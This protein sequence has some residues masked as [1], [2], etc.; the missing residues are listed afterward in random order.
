[1][2]KSPVAQYAGIKSPVLAGFR[3]V[4][5]PV[6]KNTLGNTPNKL[7]VIFLTSC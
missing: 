2:V 6:A 3:A 4:D 5:I 1:M 7:L